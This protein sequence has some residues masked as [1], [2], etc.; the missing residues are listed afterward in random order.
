MPYLRLLV[1]GLVLSS[2]LACSES[3]DDPG[4][5]HRTQLTVSRA[6]YVA[7]DTVSVSV[8]NV[9]GRPLGYNFCGRLLLQVQQDIGQWVSVDQ[10]SGVPGCRDILLVLGVDQTTHITYVLPVWLSS[11]SYRLVLP[12]P[13]PT[14]GDDVVLDIIVATRAFSVTALAP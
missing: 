4:P 6:G 13:I 1:M 8:R 9:S 2:T 7:G 11:G 5:T 12:E 3:I 10:P 14:D